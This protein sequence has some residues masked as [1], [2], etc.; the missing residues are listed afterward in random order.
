[1]PSRRRSLPSVS[2]SSLL[3]I[4]Q[5]KNERPDRKSAQ[6]DLVRMFC[7]LSSTSSQYVPWVPWIE[8]LMEITTR[9]PN[10]QEDGH[11]SLVYSS[12]SRAYPSMDKMFDGIRPWFD[13]RAILFIFCIPKDARILDKDG[14]YP[15]PCL[16]MEANIPGVLDAANRCCHAVFHKR[17]GIPFGACSWR[18]VPRPLVPGRGWM[19]G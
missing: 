10:R 15:L 2:R 12:P 19:S 3:V 1:M 5:W 6:E 4:S 7:K 13:D 16:Y 9:H 11:P 14:N 17:M 8:I 18:L